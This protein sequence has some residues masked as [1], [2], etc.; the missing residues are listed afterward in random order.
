MRKQP[1]ANQAPISG[2]GVSATFRKINLAT[3]QCTVTLHHIGGGDA[4]ENPRPAVTAA[5]RGTQTQGETPG[6]C[7]QPKPNTKKRKPK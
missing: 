7:T 6:E 1:P 2:G 5:D 3:K 4:K